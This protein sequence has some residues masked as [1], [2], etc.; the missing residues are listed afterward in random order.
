MG[1]TRRRHRRRRA[2]DARTAWTAA[3]R[4]PGRAAGAGAAAH[5]ARRRRPARPRRAAWRSVPE[6][7]RG[8]RHR[9]ARD[10]AR[11]QPR[12]GRRAARCSPRS[13]GASPTRSLSVAYGLARAHTFRRLSDPPDA[14]ADRAPGDAAIRT[15][16]TGSGSTATREDFYFAVGMAVYPNRG[17]IDARVLDV[18]H[19]GVQRSVF[20]SGRIPADRDAD[21]DRSADDR[22]RRTA[23]RH[24]RARRRRRS[25]HRRRRHVHG[26]HGRARGAAPDDDDRHAR[27]MMDSTR[28]TQWGTWSGAITTGGD[29]DRD[30]PRLRH[31]GPFVGRASGRRSRA[32]AAPDHTLPQIFFLWA[33]INWD[34]CCTHFLCFERGERR[35]LRRQPGR[36]RRRSAP[37]TRRGAPTPTTRIEHLAG[38]VADVRWA[39]ACAARRARRCGCCATTAARSASSSNRC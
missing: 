6:L 16:T 22:D 28:L 7:R 38:T 34:D 29:D 35:S 4:D 36:A 9:H 12:S 17:I 5:R 32:G 3:G 10:A 30:R 18:V 31:E 20:A 11:V 24:A 19:D 15:T 27:S 39:P 37:A 21:A 33:P 2:A 23:A 1:E 8:R 13:C 26:A 25:R 14:A